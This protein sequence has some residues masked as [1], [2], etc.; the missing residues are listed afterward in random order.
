MRI[1]KT[2]ST[3]TILSLAILLCPSQLPS[4]YTHWCGFI[5]RSSGPGSIESE[6]VLI[7]ETHEI[8]G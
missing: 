2:L 5:F 3:F 7:L 1:G 6:K 4:Q 8:E